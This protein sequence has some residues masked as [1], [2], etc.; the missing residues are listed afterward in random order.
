MNRSCTGP[1]RR[2]HGLFAGLFCGLAGC[3]G[4]LVPPGSTGEV[5]D[6]NRDESVTSPLGK[7]SGEPNGSFSDPVAAVFDDEGVARLQ[8]TVAR[9]GDLDV[10]LLGALAP[11][12]RVIVTT[13][14]VGSAL[15]SSVA[16]FDADGRMVF[17]NDDREPDDWDSFVDF[18]VRH[19]GEEY[20]LVVTHAAFAD[21]RGFTG[22][23]NVDVRVTPGFTVPPPVPQTLVLDFDGGIVDSPIPGSLS[24]VPFDAA[25]IAPLYDGQ[26]ETI[27]HQ[28][29][30]T[31]EQN[32]E[33]FAIAVFTTD[34]PPPEGTVVSLIFFGGF[35]R[36]TFGISEDVD[37]YNP[38]RC[39][40]ALIYAESFTPSVFTGAPSA[41]ELGVAIGNV[42]T[43]EAG[44]LLGLNH[45]SD[46][47]DLMDDVSPADA[48]LDDQEFMES[49][50][51]T[52]I[53]AIGTQD[54][55][56]LLE[57]TVGPSELLAPRQSG[58]VFLPPNQRSRGD[59]VAGR[60]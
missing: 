7:T 16:L 3:P 39:D 52:D 27:Q 45:V 23:Y 37:L 35:D 12:D 42:A 54:G 22:T 29:R 51:S 60:R 31:V 40:D 28:I 55:V 47:R 2:I 58:L 15:D 41:V 38:D 10:F 19:A 34:D 17:E 14:T 1:G 50:L 56:L 5:I 24:L 32:F 33:R 46:D 13:S 59:G 20:Y 49:P 43:H 30:E 48:F 44:H 8:G 53:M 11:G 18:I 6:G 57:E 36:G 4:V 9:E 26:T 25:H 21:S